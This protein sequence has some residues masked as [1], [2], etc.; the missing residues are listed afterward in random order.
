MNNRE[1]IE[2]GFYFEGISGVEGGI[3][4]LRRENK[5]ICVL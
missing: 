1:F 2:V 5:S 4:S 3:K